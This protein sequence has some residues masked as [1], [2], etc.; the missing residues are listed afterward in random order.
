M[1]SILLF[2]DSL[3]CKNFKAISITHSSVLWGGFES[4]GSLAWHVTA[5]GPMEPRFYLET[6]CLEGK[7]VKGK[8]ALGRGSGPSLPGIY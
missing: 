1:E 3:A 8:C 6:R 7:M 4:F 2:L 5:I